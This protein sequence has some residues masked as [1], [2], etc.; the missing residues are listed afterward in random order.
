MNV[1]CKTEKGT[2]VAWNYGNTWT[3]SSGAPKGISIGFYGS[4]PFAI[5]EYDNG[6]MKLVINKKELKEN[7][8]ELVV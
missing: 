1:M 5:T 2:L 4:K 6:V 8:I 3:D 7:G